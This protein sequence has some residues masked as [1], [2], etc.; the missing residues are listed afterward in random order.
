MIRAGFGRREITRPSRQRSLTAQSPVIRPAEGSDATGEPVQ[1]LPRVAQLATKRSAI[2]TACAATLR[3]LSDLKAQISRI[4]QA[5]MAHRP[6]LPAAYLATVRLRGCGPAYG[7]S[8]VGSLRL[9]HRFGFR[10]E[11][12]D[13]YA[14]APAML[15]GVDS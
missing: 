13:F 8:V 6:V 11:R 12:E 3:A 15:G 7:R 2:R 10:R 1:K 5:E 4:P 9:S 14:I